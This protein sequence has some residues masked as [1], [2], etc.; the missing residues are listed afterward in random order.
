VSTTVHAALVPRYAQSTASA[1]TAVTELAPRN[2]NDDLLKEVL[3]E[4]SGVRVS[5]GSQIC[6]ALIAA[7]DAAVE[8][9]ARALDQRDRETGGHSLRVMELTVKVVES[10]GMNE[11]EV[12]HA[13]WG[14]LLHDIGKMEVPDAILFKRGDLTEEEWKIMRFHPA[15]AY[16][17]LQPIGFLRPALDIPCYHHEK[18]DGTGY[19]FRLKQDEI[20]VTARIFAVIDV[21]DAL[22]SDRPYREAWPRSRALDYI[23]KQAGTHFDP[24]AVRAVLKV[25]VDAT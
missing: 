9:L 4:C 15:I 3:A 19:P 16:E 7:Y 6:Q 25:A 2:P 23:R 18:W 10:I 24:E 22:T 5:S 14:A 1:V 12:R 20:P 13:R 11:A 8:V 21:L 17:I